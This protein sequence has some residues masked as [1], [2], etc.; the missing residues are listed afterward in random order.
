MAFL[1]PGPNNNGLRGRMGGQVY[2]GGGEDTIV[3]EFV[4]PV[5]PNTPAQVAQQG[6]VKRGSQGWGELSDTERAAWTE[7]VETFGVTSKSV[8]RRRPKLLTGAQYFTSLT[9]KFLACTPGGTVPKLP[10]TK[11]FIGDSIEFTLSTTPGNIVVTASGPN[12]SGVKTEIRVQR[13][14]AAYRKPSP[15]G[16]RTKAFVAF[17]GTTLSH[18]IP[19]SAGAYAV[20]VQFVDVASGAVTGY[21]VLP[22]SVV[23]LALEK[24]GAD[25]EVSLPK[26]KAA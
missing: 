17:S 1:K 5:Q 26:A 10:P 23:L 15:N 4:E 6:R 3:R 25:T 11:R 9:S 2:A 14:A 12:S 20:A 19:V 21:E 13:L 24:G 7:A 8:R 16:F 22:T 18:S